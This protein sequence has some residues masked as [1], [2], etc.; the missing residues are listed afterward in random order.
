MDVL[1]TEDHVPVFCTLSQCH[2]P[3]FSDLYVIFMCPQTKGSDRS[4]TGPTSHD[5]GSSAGELRPWVDQM[6]SQVPSLV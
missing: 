5:I 1:M 2:A 6:C 3:C 4:W